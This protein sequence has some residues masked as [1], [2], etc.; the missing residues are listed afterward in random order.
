LDEVSKDERSSFRR[1]GRSLKNTRAVQKGV[2]IRGRRFSAEGLLTL[3]G[4]ISNTVV[5][6][7][8]TRERYLD[9]LE[10]YVMPL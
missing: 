6:G 10:H 1:Y 9:Y 3:D 4:M 2:F 8:M 7:S 5:E